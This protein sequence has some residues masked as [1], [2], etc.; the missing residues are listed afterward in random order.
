MARKKGEEI[1]KAWTITFNDIATVYWDGI[2]TEE[3]LVSES[4]VFR[5]SRILRGFPDGST[6]ETKW[7][8]EC[9][10]KVGEMVFL[11][12]VTGQITS[13]EMTKK[14]KKKA[15]LR[16]IINEQTD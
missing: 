13:R 10:V 1:R 16:E 15:G 4:G 8:G 6:S 7:D 3:R 11:D 14:E 9:G 12:T 2:P 5:S